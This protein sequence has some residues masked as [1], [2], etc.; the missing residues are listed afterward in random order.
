MDQYHKAPQPPA[1]DPGIISNIGYT[2]THPLAYPKE[3]IPNPQLITE[4]HPLKRSMPKIKDMSLIVRIEKLEIANLYKELTL[5]VLMH[6]LMNA[7]FSFL[8][9]SGTYSVIYR[10]T[11]SKT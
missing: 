3:K 5:R 11:I 4:R 2:T 6:V 7:I 8:K 10:S 9:F 1:Y